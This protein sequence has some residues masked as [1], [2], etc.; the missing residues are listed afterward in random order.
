MPPTA[1]LVPENLKRGRGEVAGLFNYFSKKF[2][3]WCL[4]TLVIVFFGF[5]FFL[6]FLF[7]LFHFGIQAIVPLSKGLRLAAIGVHVKTFT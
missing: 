7:L 2:Y 4:Q 5:P 3:L 6:Q 1:P